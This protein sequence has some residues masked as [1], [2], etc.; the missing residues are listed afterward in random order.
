M[1][2]LVESIEAS[3]SVAA[4]DVSTA[5]PESASTLE[6]TVCIEDMI[7]SIDS[8][9]ASTACSCRAASSRIEELE[10]A[11]CSVACAT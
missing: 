4:L 9:V 8:A 6:L 3:S 5:V 10:D 1:W 7:R 11:S 2:R